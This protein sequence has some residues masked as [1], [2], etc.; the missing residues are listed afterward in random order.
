[1]ELLV[2][3]RRGSLERREPLTSLYKNLHDG[4]DGFKRDVYYKMYAGN[5]ER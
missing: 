4:F 5:E 1:M 2:I 3:I